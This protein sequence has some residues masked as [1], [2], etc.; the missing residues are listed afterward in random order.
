VRPAAE[1]SRCYCPSTTELRRLWPRRLCLPPSFP[2]LVCQQRSSSLARFG[3]LT[4]NT[5]GRITREKHSAIRSDQPECVLLDR[6]DRC[7]DPHRTARPPSLPLDGT[8][9]LGR[10]SRGEPDYP[11]FAQ[12]VLSKPASA[13]LSRPRSPSAFRPS[14]RGG[15]TG[16]SGLRLTFDQ[17]YRAE[18]RRASKP[19]SL[20]NFLVDDLDP[21]RHNVGHNILL[22]ASCARSGR[23]PTK[24]AA[25]L[26]PC[27][28]H[29]WLPWQGRRLHWCHV[30]HSTLH[31]VEWS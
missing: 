19:A 4:E 28:V 24:S 27:P 26:E 21:R 14:V 16:L 18:P 20:A 11:T 15:F 5:V 31:R 10:T 9:F 25:G 1:T 6:L 7:R 17:A 12:S 22:C 3:F 2:R 13:N 23:L 8:R 30:C 29:D